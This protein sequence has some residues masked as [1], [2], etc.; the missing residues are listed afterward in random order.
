MGYKLL[1]SEYADE[2]LDNL[3]D[4]LIY[5]LKNKQ[6]A[7]HLL[8]GIDSIYSRLQGNP[9]SIRLLPRLSHRCRDR[10][11]HDQGKVFDEILAAKRMIFLKRVDEHPGDAF[12]VKFREKT[13]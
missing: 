6:A 12:R 3:I 4:Y 2:L 10:C 9:Y 8:D 1:I 13:V 11:A 5:H 7:K